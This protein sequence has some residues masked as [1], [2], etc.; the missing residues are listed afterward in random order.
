MHVHG[1]E[2]DT[3]LVLV[4]QALGEFGSRRRLARTLE[5]RQQNDDWRLRLEIQRRIFAAQQRDQLAVNDLDERLAGSQALCNLLADRPLANAIDKRLDDGQR[6]VRFQQGESHLP[7]RILD[8]GIGETTFPGDTAG[9]VG[10]ASCQVFEHGAESTRSSSRGL[11][12]DRDRSD[13]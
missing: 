1:H 8:I 11:R 6:Y 7:Q 2:H 5:A 9:R 3:L 10:Q 13:C 4:D 12:R